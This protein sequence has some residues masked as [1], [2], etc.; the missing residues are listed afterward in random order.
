MQTGTLSV[1]LWSIIP[2]IKGP[3]ESRQT[4][5]RINHCASCTMG[6]RPTARGPPDQLPKFFPL[7]FDVWTFSV[8]LNVTMTKKVVTIWGK[9]SAEKHPRENPGYTYEKRTPALRWYGAPGWLIQPWSNQTNSH[10]GLR[11]FW[12]MVTVYVSLAVSSPSSQVNGVTTC[13]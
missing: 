1:S 6:G 11:C 3:A 9:K 4:Q 13:P 8:S 12:R 10:S 2:S 7:C 5:G